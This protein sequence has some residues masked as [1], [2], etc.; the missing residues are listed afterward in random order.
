M[1]T[2]QR[3]NHL[4]TESAFEVL[5]KANALAVAGKSIINLSIG[6]PN[7]PT[8]ANIVEAGRKAFAD[9]HHGYTAANGMPELREAVA[10]DI[11]TQHQTKVSA[12]Q[13]LIVPGGKVTMAFAMLVFQESIQFRFQQTQAKHN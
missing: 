2:A 10:E 9:G 3:T 8:P 1:I 11:F 7:F 5:A 6:Q 4:G 12:D 13:I